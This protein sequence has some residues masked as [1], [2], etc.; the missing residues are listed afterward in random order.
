MKQM[1]KY[2]K[3]LIV[4]LIRDTYPKF[5]EERVRTIAREEAMKKMDAVVEQYSESKSLSFT[6][7]TDTVSGQ[8]R[9]CTCSTTCS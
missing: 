4:S 6:T 1:K 8:L 9:D 5:D 3:E 2:I 7:A